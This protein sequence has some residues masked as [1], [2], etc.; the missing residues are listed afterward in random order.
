MESKIVKDVQQRDISFSV[1]EVELSLDKQISD[2]MTF[3]SE[4]KPI[5]RLYENIITMVERALLNNALARND[6]IKS[7]AAKY[8]GINRNT[9]QAKITKL[10][11]DLHKE[12]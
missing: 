12:K 8:L 7:N 11:I 4:P 6:N 2:V 5:G 9:L 1:Q 10:G 3:L